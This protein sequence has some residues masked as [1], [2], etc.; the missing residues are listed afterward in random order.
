MLSKDGLRD[1]IYIMTSRMAYFIIPILSVLSEKNTLEIDAFWASIWDIT[2]D[3]NHW[4]T[5]KVPGSYKKIFV[6]VLSRD[7]W[8]K[9]KR[10]KL[11]CNIRKNVR[12]WFKEE[13]SQ[14]DFRLV[15]QSI[16]TEGQ[17]SH[18]LID[19]GMCLV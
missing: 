11:L 6:I 7:P 18:V 17:F 15:G 9:K 16:C 2:R 3:I 10:K 19:I 8:Y 1:H 12:I 5:E 4:F 14:K 13:K